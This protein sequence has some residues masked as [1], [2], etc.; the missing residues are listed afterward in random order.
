M[1][2]TTA[3][4]LRT[5]FCVASHATMRGWDDRAA[6][7][8]RTNA[9]LTSSGGRSTRIASPPRAAGG[10]AVVTAG[11]AGAAGADTATDTGA[12]GRTASIRYARYPTRPTITIRAASIHGL[13]TGGRPAGGA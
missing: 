10:G 1:L 8:L 11:A 5:R 12:R 7:S 6:T 9:S 3:V 13:N 2:T 4:K